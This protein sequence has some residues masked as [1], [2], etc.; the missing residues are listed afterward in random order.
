LDQEKKHAPFRGSKLTLVLRDSFVG[1]CRTLMIANISP[2]INNSEHTLNTLRYAD[3][4]KELRREKSDDVEPNSSD[5]LSKMLMM[6]RQHN[7]TVKYKVDRRNTTFEK[8]KNML[9]NAHHINQYYQP[10]RSTNGLNHH[11]ENSTSQEFNFNNKNFFNSNESNKLLYTNLE[12]RLNNYKQMTNQTT[13]NFNNINNVKNI[14][15]IININ[16]TSNIYDFLSKNTQSDEA[17]KKKVEEEKEKLNMEHI[18]IIDSIV[19]EEQDFMAFHRQHINEMTSYLEKETLLTNEMD[20]ARFEIDDYMKKL[21]DF[22]SYKQKSINLL[23]DR[24]SKFNGLLKEE[25]N[26]LQK[27]KQYEP[28]PNENNFYSLNKTGDIAQQDIE[29][30]DDTDY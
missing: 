21:N 28:S 23:K 18:K 14:N 20:K 9:S 10:T 22:C 29:L 6:P 3:R 13:H 1:N 8:S 5:A 12:N 19:K 30:F 25:F 16:D 17:S 4:V 27:I 15:Q 7:N 2:S 11:N 24:I 26:I